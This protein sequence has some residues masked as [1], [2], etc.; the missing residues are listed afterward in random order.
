MKSAFRQLRISW[1]EIRIFKWKNLFRREIQTA[2]WTQLSRMLDY[3]DVANIWQWRKRWWRQSQR[4]FIN[5]FL[6]FFFVTYGILW[7]HCKK[8]NLMMKRSCYY[9]TGDIHGY[10]NLSPRNSWWWRQEK[11]AAIVRKNDNLISNFSKTSF[12]SLSMGNIN[13]KSN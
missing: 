8:S 9:S 5:I 7:H 13:S 4:I 10:S 11:C 12:T 2:C 3:F 6:T 1:V